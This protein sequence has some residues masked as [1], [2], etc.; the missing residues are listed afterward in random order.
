MR[1]SAVAALV[2]FVL[3]ACGSDPPP[4]R[5]RQARRPPQ[6]ACEQARATLERQGRDGGILFDPSGEAMIERAT[7]ME[8]G[9]SGRDRIVETL[10]VI[11]ACG[12]ETPQREVQVQVRDERGMVLTTRIVEPST[13]FRAGGR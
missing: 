3:A 10:A 11:A 7:W 8:L 9:D 4:P 1:I 2:A 5:E 13:D 6:P 12:A